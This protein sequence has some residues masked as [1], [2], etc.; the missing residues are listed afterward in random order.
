MAWKKIYCIASSSFSINLSLSLL[1]SSSIWLPSRSCCLICLLNLLF[2]PIQTEQHPQLFYFRICLVQDTIQDISIDS[3]SFYLEICLLFL[4]F[5]FHCYGRQSM[6]FS[7]SSFCCYCCC[8]AS[9]NRRRFS[10]SFAA[11]SLAPVPA[12]AVFSL[13]ALM[14]RIGQ[15]NVAITTIYHFSSSSKVVSHPCFLWWILLLCLPQGWKVDRHLNNRNSNSNSNSKVGSLFPHRNKIDE[16]YSHTI[17]F[18]ILSF[19]YQRHEPPPRRSS[20]SL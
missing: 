12:Q 9:S 20:F 14:I 8:C 13:S 18:G 4:C 11:S 15:A 6:R 2:I 1:L 10:S 19:G 7:S 5:F 17:F 16:W 3:I